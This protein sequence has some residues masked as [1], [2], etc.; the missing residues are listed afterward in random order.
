MF[1]RAVTLAVSS[2]NAHLVKH[3]D[4]SVASKGCV[5]AVAALAGIVVAAAALLS[6]RY[7][8]DYCLS[9]SLL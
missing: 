5:I 9:S 1:S 4:V 2:L 8:F 6:L 7:S 3:V